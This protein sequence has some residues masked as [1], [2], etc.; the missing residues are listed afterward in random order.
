MT[1]FVVCRFMCSL[2]T[3]EKIRCTVKTKVTLS[4][5]NPQKWIDVGEYHRY[6][7]R[8]GSKPPPKNFKVKLPYV[9]PQQYGTHHR[10]F[11]LAYLFGD[12]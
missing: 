11:I 4:A 12:N 8:V 5:L 6:I 1:V 7:D 2:F 10:H 9:S 3:L